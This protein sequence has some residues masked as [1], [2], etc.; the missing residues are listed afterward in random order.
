[1]KLWSSSSF[2]AADGADSC[3][4]AC[5]SVEVGV[6]L[7]L[8]AIVIE[9]LLCRLLRIFAVVIET[10]DHAKSSFTMV[11]AELLLDVAIDPLTHSGASLVSS[12]LRH[13]RLQYLMG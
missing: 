3:A 11:D 7:E 5:P 4:Q 9:P 6:S 10:S 13:V 8:L 2:F 12:E 1:M